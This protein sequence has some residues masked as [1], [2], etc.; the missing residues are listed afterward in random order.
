MEII[1][2]FYYFFIV[3]FKS[4]DLT[5]HLEKYAANCLRSQLFDYSFCSPLGGRPVSFT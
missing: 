1:E 5:I 3:K 2:E 4:E